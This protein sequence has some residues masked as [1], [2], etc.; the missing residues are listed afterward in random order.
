MQ[1]RKLCALLCAALL[2]VPLGLVGC[3]GDDDDD[4]GPVAVGPGAV[5]G[6]SA[7]PSAD[8]EAIAERTAAILGLGYNTLGTEDVMK[9]LSGIEGDPLFVVDTR[10]PADFAAGHIPGAINIPLQDLP[11]AL[12][13]G[14]SGIPMDTDV[15]VASYWGNDG[16][17]ASFL[18]NVAR[19][20]DPDNP[21]N[22]PSSKG[23]FQGMTSWS[24]D[25][26]LVPAN[27]RFDD[28][29]AAGVRV[30]KATESGINAGNDQG[31]FPAFADFDVTPVVEKILVRGRE[32]LNSASSQLD[33]QMF[34]G[35]L[36]TLL[37]DENASNDPQIISVRAA[38]AYEPGHIPGAVNVPYRSVADLVNFTNLVDP[39]KP[40]V[41]YCYTGH[42]GSLSTVALGILGYEVVN[43]LY[44]MNG[45]STSAPASGQLAEFDTN[46]GWDFPLDG[47]LPEGVD[48]LA[49]YDPP[50]TGCEGCHTSLTAIWT[51]LEEAP[52]D[53][54]I[55]PPSSGEG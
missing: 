20:T 9:R 16:N 32:Y 54:V 21:D 46:R 12:L 25:R 23:L 28:A 48:S 34:P 6:T 42:T 52:E 51:D 31:A 40:V 53:A 49:D 7:T 38:S 18:I 39:G 11:Q 30:E 50:S 15:V 17:M 41:V 14:T 13:D 35:D 3:G 4:G 5:N 1:K 22:F 19:V 45:W 26:D 43:L 36:A 29:L 27:T 2:C 55:L 24:F 33:L 44:G 10:E 8:L 47:D 37:E